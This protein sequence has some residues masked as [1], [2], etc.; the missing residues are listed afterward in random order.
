MA[1]PRA[2]KI[3]LI[4]TSRFPIEIVG[5]QFVGFQLLVVV[6]VVGFQSVGCRLRG[7]VL[8]KTDLQRRKKY[9]CSLRPFALPGLSILRPFH[10]PRHLRSTRLYVHNRPYGKGER[11]QTQRENDKQ[12]NER[13]AK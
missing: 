12:K 2:D 6:D 3:K 13:A 9:F 11:C 4:S 1:S 7:L 10:S 8:I 5:F